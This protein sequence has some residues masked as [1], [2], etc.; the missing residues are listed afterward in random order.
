MRGRLRCAIVGLGRIGS[1]LEDDRLREKPASHAG[2]IRA[3][4][5][6]LLV[7]GCDLR[8]DRREAFA[9]R[10]G[11]PSVYGDLRPMLEAHRPHVLHVATPAETH[12][13][14]IAQAA[15]LG[16]PLVVCEKPLCTSAAD[17]RAAV[18]T[19]RAGGTLLMVNHERRYSR[20]YRE[21]RSLVQERRYGTLLS[22]QARLYM[23]RGQP[24]GEILLEDGTHMVDVIRYVTGRE[25]EPR[26]VRG[27]AGSRDGTLQA[28]FACGQ[29]DGFLEVSGSHEALVF[30][31]E[32]G[33]ERGRL[34]VGNG[35]YEE[36]ASGPSRYY[37]GFRSLRAVHRRPWRLTGYFVGMLADAVAVLREPGRI[38][39]SSGL[40]G[41]RA[42]ETIETIVG[43]AG[44]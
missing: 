19:C 1:T 27:G 30:E 20:D 21:A 31:L 13:L 7:A 28:L 37:E 14:L 34:R 18:E 8:Q 6:C 23:G 41:L 29:A 40:D 17:A 42:I 11:C 3:S 5:D 43:S 2:A 25:I 26:H 10:W 36:W 15:E 32:L 33:F 9:R 38:P 16:V 4:R 44:S 12:G 35:V 39:V 22:L 24:L